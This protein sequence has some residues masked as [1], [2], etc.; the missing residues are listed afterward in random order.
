MYTMITRV[1]LGGVILLILLVGVGLF[2][3]VPAA[4]AVSCPPGRIPLTVEEI[5][6]VAFGFGTAVPADR[7]HQ[8]Y[9]AVAKDI[10]REF[11]LP[12]T[13]P[14]TKT[15]V[16]PDKYLYHDGWLIDLEDGIDAVILISAYI[17]G[18]CDYATP[19]VFILIDP[20]SGTV[21]EF[22]EAEGRT[23][24]FSQYEP[25]K[26]D[27]ILMDK[28]PE[29]LP[30]YSTDFVTPTPR[31][32][33]GTEDIGSGA[34]GIVVG[35]ENKTYSITIRR[36]TQAIIW[37]S[38]GRVSRLYVGPERHNIRSQI[39]GTYS[40]GDRGEEVRWA[41]RMLS[42]TWSGWCGAVDEEV[43]YFGE[44]TKAALICFQRK[45]GGAMC[46]S[47]YPEK[48]RE[49]WAWENKPGVLTPHAY[50]VLFDSYW[51]WRL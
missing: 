43:S 24:L 29:V 38:D 46:K 40:V 48:E 25:R 28:L 42:F 51:S 8:D 19:F 35:M 6:P 44:K 20:T 37:G 21:G 9:V 17:P 15:S 31:P 5:D 34:R 11:N 50:E 41:K 22:T 32:W 2:T 7:Q 39:K 30:Q 18:V 4:H 27:S 26:V 14:L 10:A 13:N 1:S 12:Y 45:Y 47:R 49:A 36:K 16:L 23:D 3:L 33:V